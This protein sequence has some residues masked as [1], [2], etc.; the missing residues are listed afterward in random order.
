MQVT[1]DSGIRVRAESVG[2]AIAGLT[3]AFDR[4]V[5][6]PA[7]RLR[8][9]AA[10]RLRVAGEFAWDRKGEQFATLYREVVRTQA[11]LDESDYA[12]VRGG[13]PC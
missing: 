3:R 4:L 8:M 7:L 12:F 1:H 9:G 13:G 2:G 6:D 11:G 5:S 10:G